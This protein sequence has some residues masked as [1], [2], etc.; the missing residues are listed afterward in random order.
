MVLDSLPA[1]PP[2]ARVS[3]LD[4][5]R[6]GPEAWRAQLVTRSGTVRPFLKKLVTVIDF[7]ATPEGPPVLKA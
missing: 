6:R 7:G 4:R 2:G 3:E 5:L 1:V